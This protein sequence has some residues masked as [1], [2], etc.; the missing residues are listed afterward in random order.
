MAAPEIAYSHS[1]DGAR[2]RA[3][4]WV[5]VGAAGT[6][7]IVL[8]GRREFIEKYQEVATDLVGRG[9]TVHLLEWRGQGLSHRA[10]GNPQ[11]LWIDDFAT[12][13]RDLTGWIADRG[14]AVPAPVLAHSMG[15]ALA[16]LALADAPE[17]FSRAVLTAPMLGILLGRPTRVVRAL[18]RLHVKRGRGRRYA[19]GQR[20]YDPAR[21]RLAGNAMTSDPRRGAVQGD[22]FDENPDVRVGGVTWGW[23]D[24]AYRAM[25]RAN[26]VLPTVPQPVT[27]LTAGKD[28]LIDNRPARTAAS[29]PNVTIVPF[30]DGRHELL[31]E[32]DEIRTPVL[33]TIYDAL[34]G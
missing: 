33:A 9:W 26:R 10:P 4:T 15:G 16:V 2:L 7:L 8:P 30:A 22:W 34:A 32:R 24:A 25:D 12:H 11:A 23:L 21:R 31:M 28:L 14:I 29:A 27:I 18:A 6:D 20:N 13:V 3:A 1:F 19:W 5:P 17:R